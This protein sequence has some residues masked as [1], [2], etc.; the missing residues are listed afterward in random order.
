M[1]QTHDVIKA[2]LSKLPFDFTVLATKGHSTEA[3]VKLACWGI[4]ELNG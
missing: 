4:D 3:T 2:A 1:I